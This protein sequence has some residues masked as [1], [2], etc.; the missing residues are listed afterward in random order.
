MHSLS[1]QLDVVGAK[2]QESLLLG[3]LVIA[4]GRGY[5]LRSE[6]N[7]RA[8][9]RDEKKISSPTHVAENSNPFV[10]IFRPKTPPLPP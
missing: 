2:R 1:T 6:S 10:S 3:F 7:S 9:C 5:A 8:T 4:V